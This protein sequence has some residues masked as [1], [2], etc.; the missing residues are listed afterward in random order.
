MKRMK[1][2]IIALLISAMC[3]TSVA[4][5]NTQ[6]NTDNF[7]DNDSSD[8]Y[9]RVYQAPGSINRYKKSPIITPPRWI[10]AAH[11]FLWYDKLCII[12]FA[13]QINPM[14]ADSSNRFTTKSQIST[15]GLEGIVRKL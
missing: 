11:F 5:G 2:F 1:K 15:G 3:F 8:F 10:S 13:K 14:P 9:D 4:C 7:I 6:N 12:D